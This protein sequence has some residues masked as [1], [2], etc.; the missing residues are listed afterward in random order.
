MVGAAHLESFLRY[1]TPMF[2]N[3]YTSVFRVSLCILGIGKDLVWYG[4]APS[5][6]LILYSEPVYLPNVPSN[7]SSSILINLRIKIVYPH[8][9]ILSC[10]LFFLN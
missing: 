2:V 5:K 10:C 8:F 3:L 4:L 7:I 1:N 6:S 9:G